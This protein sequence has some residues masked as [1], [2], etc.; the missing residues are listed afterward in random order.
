[1]VL[2]NMNETYLGKNKHAASDLTHLEE[3]FN[4][5]DQTKEWNNRM[6]REAKNS[7]QHSEVDYYSK[8]II[9]QKRD[10]KQKHTGKY[11]VKNIS[12]F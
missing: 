6:I 11:C 9:I 8:L 4:Q 12:Y 7:T 1:M 10:K 5:S 2:L 3:P